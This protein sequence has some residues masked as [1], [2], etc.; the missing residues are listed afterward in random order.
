M[1][2]ESEKPIALPQIVS[3]SI[4]GVLAGFIPL[5]QPLLL[6]ALA[7][8][9]RIHASNIGW[10]AM[11]EGLASA[12]ATG[13]ASVTLK[14]VR[15]RRVVVLALT[16]AVAMNL[17][18]MQ[19]TGVLPLIAI[20]LCHGV[21]CGIII[22][23]LVT[24]LTRI[25]S[26]ARLLAIFGTAM[27]AS[28]LLFAYI[29]SA[30]LLPRYGATSGYALIAIL[31]VAGL[32]LLPIFPRG[33]AIVEGGKGPG[34]P[35]GRGVLALL[36]VFCHFAGLLSIWVYAQPIG[37]ALGSSVATSRLAISAAIAAQIV[38]GLCATII[39]AKLKALPALIC[40]IGAA[41]AAVG[42]ILIGGE[43]GLIGG[44]SLIGLTW[45][46]GGSLHMP[47][48]LQADPSTRAGLQMST[49]QSFGAAAGPAVAAAMASAFG[50][51]SVLLVG[52]GLF[53]TAA[54]LAVMSL[55]DKRALAPE[56]GS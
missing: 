36:A 31:G 8:A 44:L 34:L 20:R 6:G 24:M 11:A 3:V 28:A 55:I 35:Q 49:A 7:E 40:C 30:L 21:T 54:I 48:L 27:S 47:F 33:F 25:P 13:I 17:L 32:A 23:I 18:T 39:A 43:M 2:M 9:G 15:L 38:G 12:A 1:G 4:L 42:L 56:I 19:V 46:F 5:L 10:V 41:A 53:G 16:V 14:P 51:I 45:M 22:W 50:T 52:A 37:V 29:L 26:P